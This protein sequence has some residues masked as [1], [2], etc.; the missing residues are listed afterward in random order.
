MRGSEAP[1]TANTRAGFASLWA[2]LSCPASTTPPRWKTRGGDP[3]SGGAVKP[4][5]IVLAA[6]MV[7]IAATDLAA[8]RR[9]ELLQA[10]R[11]AIAPGRVELALDLT[12]GIALAD[13]LIAEIDLDRDGAFSTTEQQGF[14]TRVTGEM[15]LS[16][17]GR[18]LHVEPDVEAF[19][20]PAALRTGDG[21]IRL[22]S[23]VALPRLSKGN[24]QLSFRNTHRPEMSVYLANALVP[25]GDVIVIN[26]QTRDPEQRGLTIDYSIGGERLA[27]LPVWLFAAG[28]V[29]WLSARHRLMRSPLSQVR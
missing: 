5:A 6:M 26:A 3:G 24:H 15:T 19:P 21:I 8:H 17:D 11:I 28:A 22:Q 7:V 25:D 18:P 12:A 1:P 14:V 13:A 20:D 29:V 10:A 9:D 2:A 4:A 23:T 16:I 27:T